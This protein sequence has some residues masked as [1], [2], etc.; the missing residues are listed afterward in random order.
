VKAV[1]DT[2][3]L[4][5][6]AIVRSSP[7]G[8]ILAELKLRAFEAITTPDLLQ[9]LE[10]VTRRPQLL[11]RLAWTE[12]DRQ[13]FLND[14]GDAAVKVQPTASLTVIK[15]DPDDNRVLEAAVAGEADYI[16]TGDKDLLNLDAFEGIRILTPAQFVAL[17]RS[18][19]P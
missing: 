15:E 2:N 7:P 13:V 6:A 14:Y 18:E 4:V 16:V 10:D 9:E 11:T 5:S 19:E 17:L 12:E 8:Q 3:V 1:L